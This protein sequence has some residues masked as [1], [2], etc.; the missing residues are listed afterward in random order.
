[1]G[2]KTTGLTCRWSGTRYSGWVWAGISTENLPEVLTLS[3]K[4]SLAKDFLI[5]RG[6]ACPTGKR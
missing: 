3:A 6:R 4:S 2:P 5:R 1:M